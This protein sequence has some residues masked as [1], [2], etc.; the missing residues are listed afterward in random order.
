MMP[1]RWGK[2]GASR[3]I[4]KPPGPTCMEEFKKSSTE[5]MRDHSCATDEC[6]EKTDRCIAK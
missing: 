2:A 3:L 1:M 6:K 4:L 5:C